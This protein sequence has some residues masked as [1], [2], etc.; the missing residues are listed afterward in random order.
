MNPMVQQPQPRRCRRATVSFGAL[1]LGVSLVSMLT[2]CGA[3]DNDVPGGDAPPAVSESVPGA[4]TAR[5]AG[6]WS[7]TLVPGPSKPEDLVALTSGAVVVSGMGSDPGGPG[8]AAGSLYSLNPESGDMAALWPAAHA[9]VVHDA[10]R[11]A[12]CTTPPAADVASPHGLGVEVADDGTE[13]LY[14]VNHGDR[15]A[16]EVFTVGGDGRAP[17][18]TWV[19]CAEL[20]PGG[21]GNGVAPDPAGDGFYVTHFLDASNNMLAQFERAFAGEP[22]GHVLHWSPDGGWSTVEGTE[23]STPNGVA[24]S[25][26]GTSLYV[27]SW[28][29]REVVE[30]DVGSG[31]RLASAPLDLM[32]DNLRAT[33][34]GTFLVTGQVID[35]FETFVQYESG[36]REPQDRYDVYELDPEGFTVERIAQGDPAGFGNP[37]T[38]LEVEDSLWV[39]SVTGEDILRLDR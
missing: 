29:G 27:A 23:M 10:E 25:E 7:G 8:G 21:F 37:T 11:F 20:P 17:R 19:G 18:L 26:D 13:Y 14:V 4:S 22:T 6:E 35:E 39:G 34:E 31:K 30:I 3:A 24:V 2:A 38:A 1:G 16:I 15:E 32:P 36:E 9:G 33:D 12:D 5:P 28:G